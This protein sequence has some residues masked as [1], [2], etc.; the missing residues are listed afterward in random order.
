MAANST[1]VSGLC[2]VALGLAPGGRTASSRSV[3]QSADQRVRRPQDARLRS[4]RAGRE[5]ST[6]GRAG[7]RGL[8]ERLRVVRHAREQRERGKVGRRLLCSCERR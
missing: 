2:G 4:R 3:F 7:P 8:C 6:S 5:R 1:D